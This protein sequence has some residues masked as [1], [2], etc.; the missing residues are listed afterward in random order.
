MHKYLV[1][2]I[3]VLAAAAPVWGQAKRRVAVMNFDYATVQS[4]SAAVFGTN[5]DIGKGI[6]DMLVDR[7][8]TDGR[9]SVIERKALDKVLAEQ[10][11]SNSDRADPSSAARL[12]KVLGVDAIIIGSITQFGRDDKSVGVAGS[13]IGSRLGRYG[14]GSVGTKDA[15]AV[16]QVTARLVNTET[17]EIIAVASGKGMSSR[18]GVNLFGGGGGYGGAGAG[19]VNMN[20]SN[21]AETIIGEATNKAVTELAGQ[22]ENN[23][24]R[25]PAKAVVIDGL[26][27]D[28]S[29]PGAIVLN[30]GSR[31]G[32]KVGD[33]LQ[34]FRTGKK[35]TDPA[36]GKVLRSM[37]TSLGEVVI[38]EVDDVSS[39]ASYSGTQPV[40]VGDRVKNSPQ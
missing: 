22:L 18:S 28:A 5:V 25:L 37:D 23:A 11:F 6:A 39:V 15:K 12:G 19:S 31:A 17:A 14:L 1:C 9:L 36:T 33:R 8:V 35:I 34:L 38:T 7:L 21:F 20:S 24:S 13:G 29:S 16:V 32:V 30:V 27:A 4:A 10:N 2:F 26:V 3:T 40:K